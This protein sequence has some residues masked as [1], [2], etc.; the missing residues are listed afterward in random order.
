M[1][2]LNLIEP[3]DQNHPR[4]PQPHPQGR[5]VTI[6]ILHN[7][8]TVDACRLI[9]SIL[10]TSTYQSTLNLKHLNLPINTPFIVIS[11]SI[12]LS[13][14]HLDDLPRSAQHAVLGNP[15]VP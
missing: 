10:N 1:I 2:P 5:P 9:A 4:L 8:V 15:S 7:I 11:W 13:L 6:Y 12:A 3:E 14:E